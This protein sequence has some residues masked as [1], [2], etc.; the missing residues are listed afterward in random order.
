MS[1]PK[2]RIDAIER[3]LHDNSCRMVELRQVPGGLEVSFED[4]DA[5]DYRASLA[6]YRGRWYWW[7]PFLK[8]DG[9]PHTGRRVNSPAAALRDWLKHTHL[10]N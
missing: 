3:V 7:T 10:E 2:K 9:Q 6:V 1:I 8:A 4:D 5:D